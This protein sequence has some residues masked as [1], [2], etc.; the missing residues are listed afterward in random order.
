MRRPAAWFIAATGFLACPCHLPVT[1][2]LAAGFLSGTSLGAFLLANPAII[3]ALFTLYFII[4]ILVGYRLL[5]GGNS[6]Q[7][8]V[9]FVSAAGA[10]SLKVG[11]AN[12]NLTRR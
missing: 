8:P 7:R 3:Y 11:K 4:G 12:T 10:G 6:K 5:S 1:L 2:G 9:N